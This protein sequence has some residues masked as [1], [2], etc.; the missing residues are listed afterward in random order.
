MAISIEVLLEMLRI[1]N[2]KWSSTEAWA[3][4][5]E[6]ADLGFLS[7]AGYSAALRGEEIV[8]MDMR[9]IFLRWED[10]LEETSLYPTTTFRTF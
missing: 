1:L 10:A 7:A 3:Q 2:N 9:E 5:M 6:V 8:K 4:K